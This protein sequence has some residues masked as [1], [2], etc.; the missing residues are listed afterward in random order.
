MKYSKEDEAVLKRIDELYGNDPEFQVINA[1]KTG[2][3]N[4][5]ENIFLKQ[6]ILS[7]SA[8]T[9]SE[10]WSWLHR[11]NLLT[12]APKTV[13]QFYV[14]HGNL[15]INAQDCYGMTPLHYAMRSKNAEAALVLLQAGANPNIPNQ[16]G[17]IPLSMIGGM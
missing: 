14:N 6:K 7:I 4:F 1:N 13:I 10:Q 5:L 3:I 17:V 15:N 9:E 2:D 11:I 8:L 16:D 12:P